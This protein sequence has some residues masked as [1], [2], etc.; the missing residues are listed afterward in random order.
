[1]RLPILL[2]LCLLCGLTAGLQAQVQ[3]TGIRDLDFGNVIAGVPTPI[4]PTDPVRSGEFQFNAG[5]N[6]LVLF[7]MTL[8]GTLQGPGATMPI[9]YGASDGL[10]VGMAGNTPPT[11]F[12]PRGFKL[13]R[14]DS[15]GRSQLFLGGEVSPAAN[16]RAGTYTATVSLTVIIIG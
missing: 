4:A 15:S 14:M 3:V 6:R 16:Q 13:Y 5:A 2:T 12:N 1:M 7:W 10:L 11:L 8:P 9:S